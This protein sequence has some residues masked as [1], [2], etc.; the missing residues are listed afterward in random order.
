M[1]QAIAD[2][3]AEVKQLKDML[4]QIMEKERPADIEDMI[5]IDEA[6]AILN[7]KKSTIYA[8]VQNGAIPHY[9]PGKKLLFKRGELIEWME[10][11]RRKTTEQTFPEDELTVVLWQLVIEIDSR[12]CV[13]EAVCP[14]CS[15]Q[16]HDE[17]V[18][19]PVTRMHKLGHV[20]EHIVY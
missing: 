20:L 5:D 4:G 12:L 19:T 13:E 6:C 8:K 10:T 3:A 18:D 14:H 2:L 15:K 16:V 17:I 1:P 7:L 11:G 9:R